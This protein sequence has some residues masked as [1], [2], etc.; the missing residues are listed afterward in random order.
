MS[1]IDGKMQ[2]LS[3]LISQYSD[4]SDITY[5][6]ESKT[7]EGLI[8]NFLYD[9]KSI[10]YEFDIDDLILTKIIDEEIEFREDLN[11]IEEGLDIIEKD[12]Y[13]SLGI[14]ES[15][16]YIKLFEDFDVDETEDF[17]LET[18]VSIELEKKIRR[19]GNSNFTMDEFLQEINIDPNEVTAFAWASIVKKSREYE[20]LSDDYLNRL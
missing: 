8:I 3:D 20:T 5:Q 2:E 13:L 17:D 16:R 14:A 6:W 9:D 11:S 1:N 12:I 4:G 15:K 7:D 10:R 19:E 18:R